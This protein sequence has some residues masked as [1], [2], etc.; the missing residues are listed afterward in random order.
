MVVPVAL[1]RARA[2][3][4][5]ESDVRLYSLVQGFVSSRFS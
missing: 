3:L 2:G 4:P 1:L 5:L